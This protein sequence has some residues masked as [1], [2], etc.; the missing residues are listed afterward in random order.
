MYTGGK[1][2]AHLNGLRAQSGPRQNVRVEF[3]PGITSLVVP[4]CNKEG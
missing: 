3:G 4:E 2:V 1:D